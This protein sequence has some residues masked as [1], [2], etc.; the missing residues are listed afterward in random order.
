M[1]NKELTYADLFE[2]LGSLGF[3]EHSAGTHR[4]VFEHAET[5][6]VLLF[7][8]ASPS[9]PIRDADYLSAEVHLSAKG[10]IDEPLETLL[11]R[12]LLRR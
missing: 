3:E 10:L 1:E 11:R 4:R 7:S 8:V 2:L 9:Q 5:D 12:E 6:A